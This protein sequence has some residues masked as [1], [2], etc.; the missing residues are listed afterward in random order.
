MAADTV[1]VLAA[2]VPLPTARTRMVR[3][4]TSP[5]KLSAMPEAVS[6]SS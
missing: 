3:P 4:A 5:L 6:W 2:V 1:K